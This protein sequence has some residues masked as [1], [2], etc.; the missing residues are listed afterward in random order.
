MEIKLEL[1]THV[2]TKMFGKKI[3]HA[4]WKIKPLP[5]WTP[6]KVHLI[7]GIAEPDGG[8]KL[9]YK[10]VLKIH[11]KT[12]NCSGLDSWRREYDLYT[13]NLK[14][15]FTGSLLMPECYHAEIN[16]DETETQLWIEYIDGI[17]GGN[18]TVE[19]LECAATELGRFQGRIYK[20]QPQLLKNIPCIK[21]SNAKKRKNTVIFVPE[22]VQY[23]NLCGK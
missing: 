15:L 13:A 17:Y 20:E 10:V 18:L 5:C 9:P 12:E 22:S 14:N 3:I 19:M 16:A 11:R 4:D 8:E 23:P 1:L 2:L 7:S 6:D 21:K